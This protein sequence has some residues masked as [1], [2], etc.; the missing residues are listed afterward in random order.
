M[1]TRMRTRLV[2]AGVI[3]VAMIAL[4][5]GLSTV[6]NKDTSDKTLPTYA[7]SS[8][9]I[10][11]AYTFALS[12]PEVLNGI[13]CYCSCMQHPHD[14]RLHS[15]GLLDCFM[16]EDGSFEKHGSECNMCIDDALD[17][18]KWDEEGLSKEE[19]NERFG[20]R[21]LNVY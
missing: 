19:I 11:E 10:E 2:S 7:K 20:I 6:L 21:Y 5:Y 1:K 16:R 13:D 18:K 8:P 4:V 17:T 9:T 15:R 14:G 3:V 12:N